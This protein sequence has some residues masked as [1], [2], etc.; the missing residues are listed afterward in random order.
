MPMN[1]ASA[2]FTFGT[3]MKFTAFAICLGSSYFQRLV[4]SI[5]NLS[6]AV[7]ANSNYGEYV[8][9]MDPVHCQVGLELSHCDVGRAAAASFDDRLS[10]SC[11]W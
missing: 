5:P 1:Q 11:S 7:R 4:S 10:V 8:A 9:Y 3:H 6:A 2:M